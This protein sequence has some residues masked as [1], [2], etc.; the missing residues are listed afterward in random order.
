MKKAVAVGKHYSRAV[1]EGEHELR[2]LLKALR[3]LHEQHA[4]GAERLPVAALP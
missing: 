2:I 4:V 1:Y 3:A